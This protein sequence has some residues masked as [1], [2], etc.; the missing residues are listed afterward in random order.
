ML[1]SILLVE[2]ILKYVFCSL[3]AFP[4]RN[5]TTN[6]G[7]TDT[8]PPPA[9]PHLHSVAPATCPSV[10]P[11]CSAAAPSNEKQDPGKNRGRRRQRQRP[12]IVRQVHLCHRGEAAA[13]LFTDGSVWWVS[14]LTIGS[15]EHV[16]ASGLDDSSVRVAAGK[17]SSDDGVGVRGSQHG[18]NPTA[19]QSYGC[20]G[21]SDTRGVMPDGRLLSEGVSAIAVTGHS[22]AESAGI[23]GSGT[24][25]AQCGEE[26][27]QNP[28]DDGVV[29]RLS[30]GGFNGF[31]DGAS[32]VIGRDD[33]WLFVLTKSQELQEQRERQ[34]L[35]SSP[36]GA[37]KGRSRAKEATTPG[38]WRVSEKWIGH[39]A[40]VTS[41]WLAG[42][43][44]STV[45]G[46]GDYVPMDARPS[47]LAAL[48]TSRLRGAFRGRPSAAGC[49]GALV[50]AAADGT[51]AWWGW[52]PDCGSRNSR[53]TRKF[54]RTPLL[55]MV[56]FQV[57]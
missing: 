42:C 8:V 27:S 21:E 44:A 45:D 36:V 16:T 1:L 28:S 12:A 32:I 24:R 25:S 15:W 52:P 17:G 38:V 51:L 11:L 7:Q 39:N 48:E 2:T 43:R 56:S 10:T 5:N 34:Q 35:F 4:Y 14:D 41:V 53:A 40:R 9:A 50:T 18:E 19:E 57:V 23:D 37:D 31:H 6:W 13:L 54:A 29:E 30:W 33:G 3:D 46:P 20:L 22:S 55:R 47:H 26:C 49:H